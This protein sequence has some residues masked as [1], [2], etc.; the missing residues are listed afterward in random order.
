MQH[1]FRAWMIALSITAFLRTWSV[2]RLGC[3]S[4]GSR[5]WRRTCHVR[6]RRPSISARSLSLVEPGEC[7]VLY[8]RVVLMLSM[9][10]VPS[11]RRHDSY[12]VAEI[13][14]LTKRRK[15][16]LTSRFESE[17]RIP[18]AYWVRTL[19]VL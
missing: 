4:L 19:V 7:N 14:A 18:G 12:G 3:D 5:E 9:A 15:A 11:L 17:S 16:D 2:R 6:S 10:G 13:R 8:S 1:R